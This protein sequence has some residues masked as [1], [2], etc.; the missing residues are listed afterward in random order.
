MNDEYI[1]VRQQ[2][3][4]L[5]AKLIASEIAYSYWT[6]LQFSDALTGLVWKTTEQ[7]KLTMKQGKY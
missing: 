6:T 1:L 2:M 7:T 3:E 5:S 4:D